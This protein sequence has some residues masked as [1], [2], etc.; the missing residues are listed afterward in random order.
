[1]KKRKA[2]TKDGPPKKTKHKDPKKIFNEAKIAFEALALI[3]QT[4]K[5]KSTDSS[6]AGSNT[7]N[8]SPSDISSINSNKSQSTSESYQSAEYDTDES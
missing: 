4:S 7:S 5:G 1:L 8:E 6:E 2:S 3:A